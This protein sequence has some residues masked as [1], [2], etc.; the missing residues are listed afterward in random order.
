MSGWRRGGP[1]YMVLVAIVCGLAGALGAVVL[2]LLIRFVQGF[3]FGGPAGMAHVVEVGLLHEAEDPLAW[4][5]EIPWYVLLFIPAAGGLLVGPIIHFYAREAKG[6]GVPEVMEAVGLRGGVIRPRVALAKIVASAITIGSGGSVGREGPIVQIG[7]GFGSAIGQLLRLPARQLRTIVGAGAAAGIAA[8]FNA[9]I[10]GALF[11]VEVI[12]GD[13]AVSQFSPIVIASVVA[14]VASR[15]F[16]GN[17]PAFPVPE[18]QLVSPLE[19]PFY[20]VIGLV[21][22]LV[23]LFFVWFLYGLE[24]FFERLAMPEWLKPALGGL[25]MG[26]VAIAIPETLGV[27]YSTMTAALHGTL[28]V[29]TL[30]LVFLGKMA[31]TSITVA[32]GG[33]GGIFAPS[34][35]LG[36]MIGGV[37]GSLFHQWFPEITAGSGAYA[38]VTMGA[39][40]AAV[41]H[42]PITAI[43]MIF[44]LTQKIEIIPPLM[45]ACVISTLLATFVRRDSIYT[46]KLRR[47][48]VDLWRYQDPNVLKSL[49]VRDILD[50]KPEVVS[51]SAGMEELIELLVESDHTEF[52]VV[53][54]EGGLLGAIYLSELRRILLERDDL[55]GIVVA[56]DLVQR[57]P[58]VREDDDL[59]QVMQ[60]FSHEEVEELAVVSPE[61]PR[62]LRGSVHKRDVIYARNQE[63]MRRD[64]AGGVSTTVAV[65]D[66]VHQVDLG[67]GYV[68]QEFLAPRAFAGRTLRELNLRSQAGVQVLLLRGAPGRVGGERIRVPGPEDRVELGDKLVVAGPK[69]SVDLLA[70]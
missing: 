7:S 40:L 33:S 19:L 59:D 61:D 14:T 18:Y 51:A 70:N 4:A 13:F 31:A 34:L 50:P 43:I 28:P 27:G 48:G 38:L 10:A 63:M 12:V 45:A 66:R 15:Y 62:A 42:A 64:L 36:A 24:D 17:N 53:D 57:R 44:E 16:L 67:G 46:L 54:H 39:V 56:E 68:V 41:T 49:Y 55:R 47:R 11:A 65:V 30:L 37:V 25:G 69:E 5:R 60:I 58:T 22:G 32:S 23:A 21:A 8:T 52:F 2:R 35:F 26:A 9:P 1:L 6:H 3:F 20:M 29:L